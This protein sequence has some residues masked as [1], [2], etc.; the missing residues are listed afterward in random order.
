MALWN[1]GRLDD[2][3]LEIEPGKTGQIVR[4][5]VTERQTVR[6]INYEGLKS[7]TNSE[8]LDRFKERKVGLTLDSAYDP[9]K[10][11]RA[12]VVLQ[13]YLAERGRQFAVVEPVLTQIPPS[14][15]SLVFRVKE[16][17]KVKVGKIDIQGNSVYSDRVIIRSMRSLKPFG[18][19]YS[20]VAE[21]IFA[22]AFDSTKLDMDMDLIRNFYQERG[23]FTARPIDY[24]L[25][26]RD[27]GGG[28]F[29]FPLLYMNS[30]GKR[31]DV[32]VQVEEGR[33]YRLNKI[34][35]TGMKAF[36][37]QGF[38]TQVFK[39]GPGDVFS[40]AKLHKGVEELQKWYG[41]YG[42]IDMVAEPIPEPV[43][44]TDKVDL[45]LNIEEG[46]QFIVR[47]IDFS[48]NTTTR[49]KVI[50]RELLLEE[51]QIYDTHAWD[52]SILRLNQLGYFEA[53]KEKEAADIKRD[54]RNNTVD[55]TLKVKERGK[56]SIGLQGGVSGIA[57]SFIGFNYS[58]NNFLG[59][60]ETLSLDT[61]LGDRM[62]NVTLGF[63]EP[64]FLDRPVS[65]GFTVYLQRFN[66][67]QLREVSLTSNRDLTPLGS[68]IG[69]DNLLNYVSNGHGFTTS[70]SSQMRKIPFGRLGLTYGYDISN[71][72]VLTPAAQAY[73][74]YINFQQG[75]AGPN[76]LNGI[77]TS[78]VTPSFSYST[79]DNPM[80]STRGKSFFVSTEF[81]GSFLGGNV[82]MIRPT[83]S[84]TYFRKGL[85]PGHV[86]GMRAMGSL[87][88]GFGGKLAPPFSRFYIGGEQDIRGFDVWGVSPLAYVPSSAQVPVLND[89]GTNRVQKMVVNGVTQSTSVYQT[90]PIYQLTQPGGDAQTVGNLEYRI[91]IVGPVTLAAFFDIGVNKILRPGQ[92][93]LTPD[94]I[95]TLNSQFPQA[96]F[97]N[98]A[99]IAKGTQNVRSS[100]GLELQVIMPVVN[101]PFRIYWAYNPLRADTVIQPPI[102][103]DRSV[104]PN[105]ATYLGAMI[106]SGYGLARPY[107]DPMRTF[108]F[109]IGRT[110]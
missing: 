11:Q 5:V 44:N 76:S 71:I 9:S 58:T 75:L 86:I 56:N 89:D 106:N 49:D 14:S 80:T 95:S 59:L 96:A 42:Y 77:R 1:T 101:A 15:L 16:G 36:K 13:E 28:K 64:Y 12:R 82:N 24:Q 110:F 69:P 38:L 99:L 31:V 53:L 55:I 105:Q 66:Y 84:T 46:P 20:I 3:R 68:A 74:E 51:G 63:T 79:V 32:T 21:N 30:P 19:P 91:P 8:V 108:R 23:Y 47:R 109:T 103:A 98:R 88:T 39:M 35:F 57:G 43:P 100:T 37:T 81:S 10:I 41:A 34:N 26:N 70:A 104:F 61:Q 18:V 83:F 92:L 107:R 48:G 87:I 40:T 6:S 50:R 27:V 22:K 7:L 85:K 52:V 54:P 29:R 102:A 78:K 4:F 33:Q 72:S 65:V 62:R 60:G 45:T 67:D 93:T 94:R 90:I 17:P 25:V 73:F 2:I 97:G